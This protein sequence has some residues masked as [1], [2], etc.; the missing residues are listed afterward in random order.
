MQIYLFES[1][2]I[3][4]VRFKQLIFIQLVIDS[5]LFIQRPELES[6]L[7]RL[8]RFGCSEHERLVFADVL[9]G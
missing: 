2:S 3:K 4:L 6:F 1:Q 8:K 9:A 7:S 5:F